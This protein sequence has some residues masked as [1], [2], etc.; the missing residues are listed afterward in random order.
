MSCYR[1]SDI[2]QSQ[3]VSDMFCTCRDIADPIEDGF[4]VRVALLNCFG[5][6][7]PHLDL[8]AQ[9]PLMGVLFESQSFKVGAG[10]PPSCDRHDDEMRF[11]LDRRSF[12]SRFYTATSAE[13]GIINS[14]LCSPLAIMACS[15]LPTVGCVRV[16]GYFFP[17]YLP[18]YKVPLPSTHGFLLSLPS[19]RTSPSHILSTPHNA[20]SWHAFSHQFHLP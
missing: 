14:H 16:S 8:S 10:L 19:L 15:G 20:F 9:R 6:Q 12:W 3:T 4:P 17:L 13:E 1:G 7:T 5:L 2:S 18:G 11:S